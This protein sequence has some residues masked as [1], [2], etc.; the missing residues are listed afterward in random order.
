MGHTLNIKVPKSESHQVSEII[1]NP[2]R[3]PEGTL[4]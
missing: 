2:E 3:R 1:T 4:R